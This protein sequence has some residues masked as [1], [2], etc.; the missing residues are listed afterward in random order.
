MDDDRLAPAD[1]HIGRR[2]FLTRSVAFGVGTG[3]VLSAPGANAATFD[4][5]CEASAS[6]SL[7][8][9]LDLLVKVQSEAFSGAARIISGAARDCYATLDALYKKVEALEA[10][11]SNSHGKAQVQQM[12]QAIEIGKAHVAVLKASFAHSRNPSVGLATAL[13]LIGNQVT[14]NAQEMLPPGKIT[15][16]PK[17]KKL[18]EE[19][20]GLVRDFHEVPK[21]TQQADDAYQARVTEISTLTNKVRDLLFA[22]SSSAADADLS[23]SSAAAQEAKARAAKQIDDACAN[24]ELLGSKPGAARLGDNAGRPTAV[25]LMVKLL[26]GTKKMLG[27]MNASLRDG[28]GQKS[29]RMVSAR[30]AASESVPESNYSRVQRALNSHCPWGTP[31]KTLHCLCLI[32][33]ALAY[34][35]PDTR[36]PLI[37]GVLVFFPCGD[38]DKG[39]LAQALAQI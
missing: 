30:F 22:A 28:S 7:I 9:Y 13:T 17:A 14:Q 37:A 31:F 18:L 1:S 35:D 34:T 27:A 8:L 23:K 16:T 11:L 19:V 29:M 32:L 33:G 25:D 4:S 38:G 24:L 36:L 5:E 20:M 2:L 15:L 39:G 10:E 6:D 12:R 21:N 3:L 26:Q